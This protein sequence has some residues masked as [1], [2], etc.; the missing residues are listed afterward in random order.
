MEKIK[1]NR[2][3]QNLK[4]QVEEHPMESIA[5]AGAT[6]LAVAKVMQA[7]T[8]RKNSKTWKKEVERRAMKDAI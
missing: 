5:I 2:F 8:E 6:A 3:Y 4:T 7:N 1:Q